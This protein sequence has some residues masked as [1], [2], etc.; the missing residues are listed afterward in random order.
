MKKYAEF[1]KED[2][3]L[4][5]GDNAPLDIP[6]I[7]STHSDDTEEFS[8][9]LSGR[10][11]VFSGLDKEA[12]KPSAEE[13]AAQSARD[14]AAHKL[15]VDTPKVDT[16]KVDT[17]KKVVDAVDDV[18]DATKAG[19][20]NKLKTFAKASPWKT[21]AIGAGI[22]LAGYGAYKALGGGQDKAAYLNDPVFLNAAL[23]G[24]DKVSFVDNKRF[25]DFA[26]S[27]MSDKNKAK[28][29]RDFKAASR[30]LKKPKG[31]L[32]WSNALQSRNPEKRAK[33]A[34]I[35]DDSISHMRNN[36]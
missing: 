1:L 32:T 27:S 20:W 5:G 12:A 16:P 11:Y 28:L 7:E 23:A 10:S 8:N 33:L 25:V 15:K 31:K 19:K 29:M 26:M 30:D 24:M 3:L 4:F 22:G 9:W 35:F 34:K 21:G 18:G 13:R 2:N 14:K 17:P 6:A 36:K